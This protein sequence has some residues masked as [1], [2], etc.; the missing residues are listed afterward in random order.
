MMIGYCKLMTTKR[1]KAG[2]QREVQK[3]TDRDENV[4]DQ[5]RNRYNPPGRRRSIEISSES[6]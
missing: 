5:R 4:Y 1:K 3:E 2:V 6:R